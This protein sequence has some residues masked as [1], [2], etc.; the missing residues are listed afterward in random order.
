VTPSATTT[1]P[2]TAGPLLAGQPGATAFSDLA[3]QAGYT[4]TQV[5][6]VGHGFFHQYRTSLDTPGTQVHCPAVVVVVGTTFVCRVDA[7][8]SSSVDEPL[9][10]DAVSPLKLEFA[11]IDPANFV[12][13]AHA[14]WVV[15]AMSKVGMACT[16]STSQGQG[17]GGQGGQ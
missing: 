11:V 8:A 16:T 17:Q 7:N 1:T 3:F 2:T 14:S 6:G 9:K 13:S 12:C 4:E 10:V 15:Q 5:E